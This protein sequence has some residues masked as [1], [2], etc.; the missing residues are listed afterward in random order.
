MDYDAHNEQKEHRV[1]LRT[2]LFRQRDQAVAAAVLHG[3]LEVPRMLDADGEREC[4]GVTALG[5]LAV[6]DALQAVVHDGGEERVDLLLSVKVLEEPSE[7]HA[8]SRCE[9]ERGQR[10]GL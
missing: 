6:R 9:V 8:V 3:R 7:E 10:T 2:H 1:A 4:R 5:P